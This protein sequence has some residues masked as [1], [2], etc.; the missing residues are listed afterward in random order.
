MH[1]H[2]RTWLCCEKR[3]PIACYPRQTSLSPLIVDGPIV[4][5]AHFL[6]IPL[7]SLRP[8]MLE[9][10][11]EGGIYAVIEIRGLLGLVVSAR[12]LWLHG[13]SC[14]QAVETGGSSWSLPTNSTLTK[15]LVRIKAI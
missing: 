3:P 9:D 6:Q 13:S 5:P 4:G 11:T 15:L 1:R 8:A 7:P 12:K 14:G 2:L 10:K